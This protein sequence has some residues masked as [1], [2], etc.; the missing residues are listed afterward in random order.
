MKLKRYSIDWNMAEENYA[1]NERVDGEMCRFADVE[2]MIEAHRLVENVA[3]QT[4]KS[5]ESKLAEA[6]KEIE[7]VQEVLGEKIND[8]I[9]SRK[10]D[11]AK[12]AKLEAK[13][14]VVRSKTI[15]ECAKV[16]DLLNDDGMSDNITEAI[17]ALN[18]GKE[19]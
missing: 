19:V 8:Y 16:A 4:I 9:E 15:E 17:R 3:S 2:M 11:D 12:I 18:S 7:E 5:L 6:E 10:A 13:A 14:K 1:T